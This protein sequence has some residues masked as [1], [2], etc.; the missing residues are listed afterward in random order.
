MSTS[1]FAYKELPKFEPKY[2]RQWARVVRDASSNPCRLNL[3]LYGSTTTTSTSTSL[4]PDATITVRAK[5]FLSQSIEFR[6]QPSLETCENRR[7]NL[8]C[9]LA[10]IWTKIPR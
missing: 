1:Q 7:R 6:Y 8:V 5:A 2:Y 3:N 4:T 10:K 9:I